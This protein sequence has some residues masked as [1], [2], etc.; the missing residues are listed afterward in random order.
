V[1]GVGSAL[2]RVRGQLLVVLLGV[3]GALLVAAPAS[4]TFAASRSLPTMSVSTASVQ[5]PVNVSAQLGSCS[6]GRWMSVTVTWDPST[7]A[8]ISGYTVKAYRNDGT[9][10]TVATTDS[11]T[12]SVLTTVD[13]LSTGSTTVTFAVVAE[14]SGWTAESLPSGPLTC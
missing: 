8:R 12:T 14:V 6:N 2:R 10:S 11:S 5:A 3:L 7:S 9:T 4:A 13:K 1:N